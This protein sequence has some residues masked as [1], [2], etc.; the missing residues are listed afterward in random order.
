MTIRSLKYIFFISSCSRDKWIIFFLT[1]LLIVLN[2]LPLTTFA[3]EVGWV[4]SLE[5]TFPQFR[6][7]RQGV[8]QGIQPYMPIYAG[9]ILRVEGVSSVLRISFADGKSKAVTASQSPYKVTPAGAT[10]TL[11]SNFLKWVSKF[12]VMNQSSH[13]GGLVAMTTR[14]HGNA[15]ELS[16]PYMTRWFYLL[17]G[18]RPLYFSWLGG[19]SPYTL[20]IKRS[21]NLEIIFIKEN[22]SDYNIVTPILNMDVGDYI[23]EVADSKG[24]SYYDFLRVVPNSKLPIMKLPDQPVPK[25][26]SDLVQASWLATTENGTWVLEALQ[27]LHVL[28]KTH[29]TAS[30]VLSVIE[31]GG[32]VD[33]K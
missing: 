31:R 30:Q 18:Q 21:A 29:S 2:C 32:A 26:T 27:K 23:F 13:S 4:E 1:S 22:I 16:I 15:T 11:T 24:F 7:T 20:Q 14:G 3:Q 10:A 28:G 25:E 19:T 12:L 9:D 6:L 5:G 17:E 33:L 8:E